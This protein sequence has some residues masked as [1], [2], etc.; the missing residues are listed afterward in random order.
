MRILIVEDEKE[1]AEGIKRILNNAGYE[2]DIADNGLCGLDLI[3]HGQYDL[4]LLDL[5][6][7]KMTGLR[8]LENIRSNGISV[9]VI[10]LTAKSQTEEKKGLD[11]GADGLF[12]LD[13][14]GI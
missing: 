1:M 12:K 3:T 4:V 13:D 11:C 9:P 14:N 8:V 6:L 7:P 2:A 5:M 10:I